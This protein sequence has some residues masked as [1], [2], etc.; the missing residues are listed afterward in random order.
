MRTLQSAF[1]DPRRPRFPPDSLARR[2]PPPIGGVN[3]PS[4][5][6][7]TRPFCPICPTTNRAAPACPRQARTRARPGSRAPIYNRPVPADTPLACGLRLRPIGPGNVPL[8]RSLPVL[9]PPYA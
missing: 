1:L 5:V 8:A 2:T 9:G 7:P 4:T 3:P 6:I